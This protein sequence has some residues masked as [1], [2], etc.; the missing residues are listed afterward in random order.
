[1]HPFS[2]KQEEHKEVT[3]GIL[4]AITTGGGCTEAGGGIIPKPFPPV[5]TTMAIG[6]NGDGP[7]LEVK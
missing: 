4:F 5:Q 3:G 2:L 1:M 7:V 6:E